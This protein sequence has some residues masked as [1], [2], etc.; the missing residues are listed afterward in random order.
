MPVDM[1]ALLVDLAAETDRTR[2]AARPPDGT[3]MA[4]ADS[5][6]R[7]DDRRPGESPCVLRRG[8]HAL[9]HG[10]SRIPR[11]RRA[12]SRRRGRIHG[13]SRRRESRTERRR[14]VDVV[15]RCTRAHGGRDVRRR[16]VETR[17]VVRV[18]DERGVVAHGAHHGD[19]GARP[20]RRGRARH[21]PHAHSCA[22]TRRASRRAG[23]SQQLP[24]APAA[25]AG[26]RHVRRARRCHRRSHG[27][28]GR[29]RR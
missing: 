23:V 20:R 9:D 17:P 3:A 6:R 1:D 12:G 14:A 18:G 28:G 27:C 22:A 4:D 13:S 24:R 16:P 25:G 2:T 7:L 11:G 29:R 21:A 10:P 8:S 15:S 19:V 26:R 5:G